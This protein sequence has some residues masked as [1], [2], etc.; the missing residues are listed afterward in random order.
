VTTALNDAYGQRQVSTIYNPLN[1]YRVVMEAMPDYLQG[2]E[3][4][5]A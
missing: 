4:W 2:P 3:S 1:Q 5:P